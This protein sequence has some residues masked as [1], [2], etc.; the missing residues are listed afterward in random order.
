M[1]GQRKQVPI[2]GAAE[3]T[4]A[5]VDLGRLS[6]QIGFAAPNTSAS[7]AQALL[8]RIVALCDAQQGALLLVIDNPSGEQLSFAPSVFINKRATRIFALSAMG[9]GE[10]LARM[11][12]YAS[13]GAD[14]QTLPHEP[15]WVSYKLPVS[16]L[17]P[18]QV[19]SSAER[20]A[21][22]SVSVML[23]SSQ[24][25][26]PLYA[27]LLLGWAGKE[28][29]SRLSR[30][31]RGRN[32]LP[33]VA[34]VA[35]TVLANLLLSEQVHELEAS[36]NRQALRE[37]ELLKAELLATVS[38]ELRS[39]L[40]SIKG[41]AATLL[42]H[43]QRISREE[44]REFLLAINEASDRLAVV[45]DRLLEMSQLETGTITIDRAPVNPVHLVREA[46]IA[47]GQ[48][49]K[50]KERV[51][52]V[53][54]GLQDTSQAPERITFTMH[55]EDQWGMSTSD[56][57]IIQAD[58]FRLREVL[59]NLLEN[60][61]NYS[62]EGGRIEVILRPIRVA[63]HVGAQQHSAGTESQKSNKADVAS[64]LPEG[65]EM[66]EVCVRDSGIGIPKEHIGRIF[67]HFHRVDT[68]LTREVNGL[69]L[70]LAICKRI[71]ELHDGVIWVESE[72]GKGSAFHV[73]LPLDAP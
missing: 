3:I 60:A 32:I 37:M 22:S 38:H 45:I 28:E 43:E 48:R 14:L 30:A 27:L 5:L 58:R 47:I 66:L 70:G 10:A 51:V 61:I 72:V 19:A 4:A 35:G 39:P 2:L 52:S 67:D 12:S 63:R 9:E 33:L 15:C 16:S 26:L 46:L 25:A 71:V 50:E 13:N 18:S 69:G 17:A 7:I 42:R 65:R 62:P 6:Q 59:D 64:S 1:E 56:E 44:R 55:L 36:I 21:N 40:A 11:D 68:R 31:E 41:Y 20:R 23:P 54:Q 8:E 24:L 49:V 57:P 34:D 53:S 73:W 29:S